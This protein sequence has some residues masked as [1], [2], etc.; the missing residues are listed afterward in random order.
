MDRA[1]QFQEPKFVVFAG[2]QDKAVT[3]GGRGDDEVGQSDWLAV[4][5]PA[6]PCNVSRGFGV[7]RQDTVIEVREDGLQQCGQLVGTCAFAFASELEDASVHLGDRQ[8]REEQARAVA[9]EPGDESRRVRMAT[10]GRA[11]TQMLV[12]RRYTP[13]SNSEPSGRSLQS[14]PQSVRSVSPHERVGEQRAEARRGSSARLPVLFRDDHHR[15]LA[16]TGDA[17]GFSRERAVEQLG[18]FG[19]GFV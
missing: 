8:D 10:P 17:L 6:E 15:F 2:Q 1:P 3:R 14:V 12:S 16:M 18:K 9:L 11:S 4:R 7:D 19:P 13:H 5:L